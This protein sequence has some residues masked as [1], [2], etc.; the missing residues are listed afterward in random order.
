MNKGNIYNRHDSSEIFVRRKLIEINLIQEPLRMTIQ[1]LAGKSKLKRVVFG[2]S[3]DVGR[4][5]RQNPSGESSG[6]DG[7]SSMTRPRLSRE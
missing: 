3:P 6:R 4:N 7:V 2:A 5:V 1:K